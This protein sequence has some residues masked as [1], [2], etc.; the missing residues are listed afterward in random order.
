MANCINR[1]SH[2][3]TTPLSLLFILA[4]PELPSH[5]LIISFVSLLGAS[6]SLED[7][8]HIHTKRTYIFHLAPQAMPST[9]QVPQRQ[10]LPLPLLP[11]DSQ[12]YSLVKVDSCF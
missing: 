7:I 11:L 2:T 12:S 3:I 9:H 6:R 1:N 8:S 4:I 10:P 5:H